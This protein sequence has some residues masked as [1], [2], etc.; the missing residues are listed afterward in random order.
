MEL[1]LNIYKKGGR[2]IEKTYSTNEVNLMFG[3]V[4]N[5]INLL[6][7]DKL[8]G[9]MSNDDLSSNVEFIGIIGNIIRGA[10]DEVKYLIMEIFPEASEEELKRTKINELIS[11][12]INVVKFTIKGVS[13]LDSKKN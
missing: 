4:E 3:T 7:F 2:E 9:I 10:F 6:D 12:I 8:T 11:L 13:G 5:I 1:T